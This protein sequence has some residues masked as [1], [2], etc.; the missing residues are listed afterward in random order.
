MDNCHLKSEELRPE[1]SHVPLL[2]PNFAMSRVLFSHSLLQDIL[3]VSREIR[4]LTGPHTP[5]S[6]SEG[7]DMFPLRLPDV[8]APAQYLIDLGLR[9]ALARRLSSLY[10]DFVARCRGVFESH[11]HR[12]IH[13]GCQHP[14]YYRDIFVVQFKG[15]I[16]VWESRIMSTAWTWLCQAGLLPP[17][18]FPDVSTYHTLPFVTLMSLCLGTR[19]CCH[20]GSDPFETWPHK[21]I[22]CY[23]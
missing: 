3:G 21:D 14:E 7:P 17:H 19:G 23:G 13:D 11:F 5:L 1:V 10:M 18:P 12:V 20:E 9:P 15:T 16:Q 6:T 2:F 8:R 4:T 22:G